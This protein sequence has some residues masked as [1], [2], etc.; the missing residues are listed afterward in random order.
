MFPPLNQKYVYI[1]TICSINKRICAK[2]S[3]NKKKQQ[4]VAFK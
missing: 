1:I 3:Q 4:C 2:M